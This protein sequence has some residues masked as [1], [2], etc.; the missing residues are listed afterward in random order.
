MPIFEKLCV[1]KQ[2]RSESTMCDWKQNNRPSTSIV[3]FILKTYFISILLEHVFCVYFV[4]SS[5]HLYEVNK[6]PLKSLWSSS[7]KCDGGK[8][9]TLCLLTCFSGMK[10]KE[11]KPIYN[12]LSQP[13]TFLVESYNG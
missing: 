9:E 12:C 6:D 8:H 7:Q 13:A 10:G 4:S 11:E 2:F 5:Y 1:F 3:I